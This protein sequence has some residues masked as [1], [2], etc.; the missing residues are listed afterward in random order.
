MVVVVVSSVLEA[1]SVQ[2]DN[3]TLPVYLWSILTVG[4]M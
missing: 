3:L 4:D 2:N 1:V